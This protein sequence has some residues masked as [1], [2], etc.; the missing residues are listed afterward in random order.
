MGINGEADRLAGQAREDEFSQVRNQANA[1]RFR[2]EGGIQVITAEGSIEG[3]ISKQLPELITMEHGLPALQKAT[4][5]SD[6]AMELLDYEAAL[7]G[8]KLFGATM[9]SVSHWAKFYTHHWYTASKTCK[10]KQAESAEC[11]C[12][13]DRVG[14]TTAHI[15]QCTDRNDVHLDHRQKLAELLADQRIPNGLLHLIEAGIDLALHSDNT[16]QGE[17]WDGDEEG[18]DEE[19]RVAQLLKDD[20]INLEYE[21]V[22]RQQTIIGWEYIFMGKCE[23][24]W[25]N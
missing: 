24:G 6:K 8:A 5:L 20:E 17:T 16:H 23:K 11:K 2:H 4:E 12:C 21:A 13:R 18:N 9:Y 25:R 7:Q 1:P 22:F 3:R 15:F 19:K 10:F 14:A